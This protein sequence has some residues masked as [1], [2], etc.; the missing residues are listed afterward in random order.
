MRFKQ[1]LLLI[2]VIVL[3]VTMVL[4]MVIS[5]EETKHIVYR[6]DVLDI[7]SHFHPPGCTDSMTADYCELPSAFTMRQEIADMLGQGM[8]KKEVMNALIAK[9]SEQS[10]AT[11]PRRGWNLILWY[12]PYTLIVIAFGA[13]LFLVNRWVKSRPK[14][15]SGQLALE[16]VQT[17]TVNAYDEK[18]DEELKKWL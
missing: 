5:A 18:I 4:P 6:K 11:P 17:S 1:W 10:L 16:G 14:A 8:S 7:A 9:Y 15:A 12:L 2:L 3:V 13:L